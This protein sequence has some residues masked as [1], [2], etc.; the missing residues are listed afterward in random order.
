[1]PDNEDL[2]QLKDQLQA[3][4]DRC[5]DLFDEA[6]VGYLLLD[7]GGIVVRASRTTLRLLD[8]DQSEMAGRHLRSFCTEDT[9]AQL[10]AHLRELAAG[11]QQRTCELHLLRRNGST[12]PVRLQTNRIRHKRDGAFRTALIDLTNERAAEARLA[13]AASVVEH[14]S[15][16]VMITNAER[17]IIAVNPAF[18]A[19]TGYAFREVAGKTPRVLDEHATQ[20][21]HLRRIRE[22][23]ANTGRW[24]GEIWNRRKGGE[25]Y[26]EWLSINEIRDESGDVTHYVA[27]FSDITSQQQVKTQLHQLAYFDSLTGLAN[28]QHF[29]DQLRNALF[30]A[31]RG[32]GM[33]GLL[34]LDLDRFK[35]I[36]DSLGHS[37]GDRLLCFV[38]ELVQDSVRKSDTVARLGGDEFTVI[39]PQIS[40]SDD[41]AKVANKI[42]RGLQAIPFTHE[43]T[44]LFIGASIGISL[45]PEDARD[46]EGL[47]R[48]AD[49]A[50]YRAKEAGRNGY[51][52][53][54]ASMGARYHDRLQ[55][56]ADL[57]RAISL[58][59]LSLCFQPQFRL[60]D[61]QMI[62]CEA[63]L[64][65]HSQSRGQVPPD[66]FIPL[67]EESGLILPLGQWVLNETLKQI[68]HWRPYIDREFRVAINV[69]AAQLRPMHA[70]RLFNRLQE[71]PASDRRRLEIELT[72]SVLM[73]HPDR[74][75]DVLNRISLL[76]SQIAIDDFGT[77]YS[78]LNYLKRFPI[79]R[80]KIDVSFVHD[81]GSD[82]GHTEVAA[83]VVAM[84][85]AL[86]VKTVAEGIETPQQLAFLRQQ[87]C[88]EGQ[89][90]LFS[91]PLSA[92][93]MFEAI[94][95]N[96]PAL[97][98]AEPHPQ[99][100]TTPAATRNGFGVL[101]TAWARLAHRLKNSNPDRT[102][103]S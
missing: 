40:R 63:L 43:G 89:G 20:S 95:A 26:P 59:E 3:A 68:S 92:E 16:G 55:L 73:D 102:N 64:R 85:R 42:F 90:Y 66:R 97:T 53:Y 87:G 36:N 37:V 49:M 5:Q 18:T 94:T 39:L 91:P 80:I 10:A 44:E 47:M 78:S 6:P 65:W 15:E 34:Y 35:E 33:I 28:R 70:E 62:G 82:K 86:G 41:A 45:Y 31:R 58:N 60:T 81:I 84:G 51:R 88:D 75:R 11:A 76:G 52:F 1:M 50:M 79:G 72:E 27:L 77:G 25:R 96:R 99:T 69:S 21:E 103:R 93:A 48:C 24:Q 56:E 2:Q 61:G 100:V 32:S 46:S 9:Q 4:L 23:L 12:L 101:R 71:A 54:A 22:Q 19:I 13:L 38:A 8:R 67:A 14:T 30:E 29:Q 98:L 7:E 74:V 83:A 57:R 17:Q